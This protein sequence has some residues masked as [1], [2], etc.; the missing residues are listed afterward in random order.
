M[1]EIYDIHCLTR[2]SDLALVEDEKTSDFLSSLSLTP[3]RALL[4]SLLLW[5]HML[6]E[7]FLIIP[8]IS[9]RHSIGL[10]AFN[11]MNEAKISKRHISPG[12]KRYPLFSG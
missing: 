5:F 12:Y 2:K 4:H 10:S 8:D 7:H 1:I 3:P 6:S 11:L 9:Y